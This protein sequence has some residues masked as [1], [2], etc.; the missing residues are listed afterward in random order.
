MS[1]NDKATYRWL[2]QTHQK[3]GHRK[4]NLG[5]GNAKI[6]S[7]LSLCLT[8]AQWKCQN[9][10]CAYLVY[11]WEVNAASHK[12]QQPHEGS[13]QDNRLFLIPCE[14]RVRSRW[15]IN[16]R[17]GWCWGRDHRRDVWDTTLGSFGA[18][19]LGALAVNPSITRAILF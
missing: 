16:R 11:R 9:W 18:G 10:P 1:K 14:D 3:R 12:G 19:C 5:I 13:R 7:N 4:I 2:V 15:L 17:D 8:K 6:M